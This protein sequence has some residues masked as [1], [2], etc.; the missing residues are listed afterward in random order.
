M[1]K[2][3][4]SLTFRNLIIEGFS[5]EETDRTLHNLGSG[6]TNYH[7]EIEGCSVMSDSFRPHGLY[8][9]WNSLG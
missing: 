4:T 2:K 9:P 3:H 1:G 6:I 8:S 7:I 5:A